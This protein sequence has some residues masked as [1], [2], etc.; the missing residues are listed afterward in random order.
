[1]D[2][3]PIPTLRLYAKVLALHGQ[4]GAAFPASVGQYLA[5]VGRGHAGAE[6][7][8]AFAFLDGWM[9]SALHCLMFLSDNF[10]TA[11]NIIQ[12]GLPPRVLAI[13]KKQQI[14]L[15]HKSQFCST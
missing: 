3:G 4:A 15:N 1:M 8:F 14:S 9:I 12:L 13:T 11:E 5:T 6:S 7:M 10:S 2:Y